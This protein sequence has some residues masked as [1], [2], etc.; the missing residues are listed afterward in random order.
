[1]HTWVPE[2]TFAECARAL[3]KDHLLQQIHDALDLCS[4]LAGRRNNCPDEIYEMWYGY[5]SAAAAYGGY[6]AGEYEWRDYPDAPTVVTLGL[7]PRL[8]AAWHALH[9]H[10]RAV[11]MPP[12]LTD[13]EL[14]LSHRTALVRLDSW[15]LEEYNIRP[16][17]KEVKI[18]YPRSDRCQ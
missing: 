10:G 9:R 11:A 17:R 8:R 15:Y 1:M 2:P 7:R 14:H 4:R 12:W 16:P 13:E 18:L 3:S 5:G 6:M